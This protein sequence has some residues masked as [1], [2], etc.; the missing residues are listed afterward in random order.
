MKK[1]STISNANIDIC[2]GFRT[3]NE[4]LDKWGCSLE[5]KSA[6]LGIAAASFTD[7]QHNSESNLF[8]NEHQERLSH[9]LNI[10][11]SLKTMFSNSENVYGFMTM[12]N[13]NPYFNGNTPLSL[14]EKGDLAALNEVSL[15]LNNIGSN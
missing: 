14:I 7:Y 11:F 2:V 12:E 6:I 4:I 8:T 1:V 13:N 15:R 9:I 3:C 10:H 5:Q